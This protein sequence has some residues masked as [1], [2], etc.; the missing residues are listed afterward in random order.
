MDKIPFFVLHRS[1]EASSNFGFSSSFFAIV[2]NRKFFVL[3]S[4]VYLTL[5][6]NLSVNKFCDLTL[7]EFGV[8]VT[9]DL[10]KLTSFRLLIEI[11]VHGRGFWLQT[12]Y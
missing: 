8:D 1:R 7:I 9:M 2:Y 6:F 4:N 10:K 11:D 5:T 12:L 3:T